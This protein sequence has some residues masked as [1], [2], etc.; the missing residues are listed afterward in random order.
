MVTRSIVG[1]SSSVDEL[2]AA[3]CLR[4]KL[5]AADE[6]VA[7]TVTTYVVELFVPPSGGISKSKAGVMTM[8]SAR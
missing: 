1:A 8:L 4:T 6:S 2:N 5:L 3:H 7:T